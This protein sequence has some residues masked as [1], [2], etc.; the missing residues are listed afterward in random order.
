MSS[1]HTPNYNLS[2]WESEDKV[3]H[4]DFN[5][6]NAKI[7][8]ALGSLASGKADKSTVTALSGQLAALEG[9]TLRLATGS[10]I[11]T[12]TVSHSIAFPFA[13]RF[14]LIQRMGGA[15]QRMLRF[16]ENA[17]SVQWTGESVYASP[18]GQHFSFS[19]SGS[20]AHMPPEMVKISTTAAIG[21]PK[22]QDYATNCL[23]DGKDGEL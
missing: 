4:T 22:G 1:K 23:D 12:G 6:D 14:V 13:P 5:E 20:T 17:V 11:G 10:Y 8:S 18:N 7:D 2:Q 19:L 3:V 15:D 21:S 16:G 9:R